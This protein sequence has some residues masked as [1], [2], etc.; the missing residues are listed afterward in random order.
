MEEEIS[1]FSE[2]VLLEPEQITV[3]SIERK[4]YH[5]M[6]AINED[7]VETFMNILS[8]TGM[9]VLAALPM[10]VFGVGKGGL[11]ITGDE[12]KKVWSNWKIVE[13]ISFIEN[14]NK[15][16]GG[17]GV[18]IFIAILIILAGLAAGAYFL[19]LKYPGVLK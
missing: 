18:A 6:Y 5:F 1:I 3:K 2:D 16:N 4:D 10:E 17:R 9:R 12:C 14:E 7:F 8:A 15:G 11:E 19:F 13:K